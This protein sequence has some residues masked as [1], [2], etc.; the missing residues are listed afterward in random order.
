[1]PLLCLLVEIVVELS[2]QW[3]GSSLGCPSCL[4]K[5]SFRLVVDVVRVLWAVHNLV[6]SHVA[7]STHHRAVGFYH[8]NQNIFFVILFL[9]R[10]WPDNLV[11]VV[12]LQRML[13]LF[14]PCV[15]ILYLALCKVWT[16]DEVPHWTKSECIGQLSRRV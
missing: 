12:P 10:L 2:T 5:L 8:W 7:L 9:Y 13:K 11:L 1:M 15:H 16:R 4:W 3:R 6:V 14:M